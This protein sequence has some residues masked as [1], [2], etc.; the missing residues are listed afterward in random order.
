MKVVDASAMIEVLSRTTKAAAIEAL[1]DDD[2]IFAPDLMIAEVVHHFRH[3]VLGKHV[4]DRVATAAIA[5]FVAA[6]IKF[7]PVWPVS[8]RVWELRSHVSAYDACY[9]AIAEDLRC[10]LITTDRKL[11]RA[12]GLHITV[13][14]P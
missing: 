12:H 14:T 4:D 5:A 1:L 3:L 11:A 9:V 6:D 8:A 7:V 2:D 13:I 10:P